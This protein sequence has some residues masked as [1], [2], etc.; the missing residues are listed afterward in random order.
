[1]K[2]NNGTWWDK[3]DVWE[4]LEN[5]DRLSPEELEDYDQEPVEEKRNQWKEVKKRIP[6][7]LEDIERGWS[8]NYLWGSKVRA[9]AFDVFMII[10]VC[11]PILIGLHFIGGVGQYLDFRAW[12]SEQPVLTK[13]RWCYKDA[14]ARRTCDMVQEVPGSATEIRRLTITEG[15]LK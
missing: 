13:V 4:W 5:L 14:L 3:N 7:V 8:H 6:T 2:N 1:M 12:A 9:F 15:E 10:A 11:S